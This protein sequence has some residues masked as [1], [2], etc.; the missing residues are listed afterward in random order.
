MTKPLVAIV[1]RPNVGKS[2]FFNR[3]IGEKLAIVEDL[4]GTTRDRLY[5]DGEWNGRYFTL[6]DTGGLEF[7][8]EDEQKKE[9][10][11][12]GVDSI[13]EIAR[14][15]RAQATV[16]IEE[17]DVIVFMVDAKTGLTSTDRDI[18][19]I[20]RRTK[21]PVLLAANRA[22]SEERRQNS[23]E[24]YELGLGDPI[25]ISSYHGTN[26]GDLLDAITENLPPIPETIEQAQIRIAIIGRPNVGKSR[27]LNSLLGQER[28]IVSDVPGTTRDAI[29]TE[30]I[31]GDKTVTLIDTAGIRRPGRIDIGVEKWSVMRTLRAINRSN[32][33][34]LVVDAS[35]GITA[36]DAHIA[37]YALEESKGIV[38]VVN[39]WDKVEKDNTTMNQYVTK[40]R[41]QLDFM[42]YVPMIFISA[43]F[44]QRVNK[45]LDA[46][47][48]VA[49]ERHKRI[50]TATLNKVMRDA[51]A[52][53]SPATKPGKWLKLL[54]VTQVEVDPPTFVFSVN[55]AKQVHFSYQRYLEN[56]IREAF[57]FEGTPLKMIFR[58]RDESD[59]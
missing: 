37:G 49:E 26:T 21:K 3:V 1:G 7:E 43:K 24:F 35:E 2:T 51:I 42:S 47:L 54:Y 39:K 50:P 36:Q 11:N 52:A 25:P 9:S 19:D 4:P 32:V 27:L 28:V 30:I 29:D 34:L 14:Q 15:T 44:G 31:V 57:G 6:I 8:S 56:K 17:A 5:G 58:G 12:K 40:I 53:H 55:D 38:L 18:A 10:E 13:R 45:V 20:L 22:D 41:E 59:D 23:V 48:T 16:A 46:A 33:V